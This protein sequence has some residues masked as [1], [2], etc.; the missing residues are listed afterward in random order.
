MKRFMSS[1]PSKPPKKIGLV[2]LNMGGPDS[3][4][5]IQPF[6]Y[7]LFSDR[8]IIQFPGPFFFQKF[9]AK[10]IA[11]KRSLKVRT[12]YQAIGGKTPL[13]EITRQQADSLG[14]LL[15]KAGHAVKTY[16]AMRYWHPLTEETVKN[17]I[18]DGISHLIV[19]SL[20]PHYS[21]A[22]TGSSVKELQRCLKQEKAELEVTYIDRW[23]DRPAY[24]KCLANSIKEGLLKFKESDR[25]GVKV[26]YSAHS[27]PQKFIDEGDPYV[28]EVRATIS[29]LKPLL[30]EV[31]A[32]LTFQSRSGPVDWVGP[33]TSETIVN[34]AKSGVRNMLMTPISFVS[35]HI[36][37][38]YEMDVMY[39]REFLEAGGRIFQRVA[40]FNHQAEF[41]EFLTSLVLE[42]LADT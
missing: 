13:T 17:I 24:L 34:L 18:G 9:L 19:L 15:A 31:D 21:R 5:A 16:V 36:E 39:K 6:L 12:R 25:A 22:T 41:L 23:F 29:G 27:L 32:M 10:R 42:Q 20:Y 3:L 8:E 33:D 38:L 4:E 1:V 11:R 35:D 14:R 26:V 30:G 2:L 28:D 7:N 40:A 37:T